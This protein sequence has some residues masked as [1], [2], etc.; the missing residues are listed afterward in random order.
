MRIDDAVGTDLNVLDE[1]RHRPPALQNSGGH[2]PFELRQAPALP[3]ACD[4]IASSGRNLLDVVHGDYAVGTRWHDK[5]EVDAQLR[6]P[7][8][9]QRH[10]RDASGGRSRSVGDTFLFGVCPLR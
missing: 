6:R 10:C 7:P 2:T 1:L 8:A 5:S 3:Y 4:L 9:S